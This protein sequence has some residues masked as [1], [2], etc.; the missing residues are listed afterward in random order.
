MQ[1]SEGEAIEA[2]VPL[3]VIEP[4]ATDDGTMRTGERVNGIIRLI[5]WTAS[6]CA[7]SLDAAKKAPSSHA[8]PRATSSPREKAYSFR[9]AYRRFHYCSKHHDELM[10][11]VFR[12]RKPDD[13]S[14]G[15]VAP[16][17]C[18]PASTGVIFPCGQYHASDQ[19]CD[20]KNLFIL[21]HDGDFVLLSYT[22]GFGCWTKSK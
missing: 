1:C 15:H 12:V 13:K 10:N 22:Y 16:T 3:V 21:K 17:T 19:P 20:F 14:D 2:N 5:S 8:F 18:E 4:A 11:G 9:E 6:R 7:T